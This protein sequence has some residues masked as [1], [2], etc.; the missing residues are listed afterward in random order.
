MPEDLSELDLDFAVAQ[1]V[2]HDLRHDDPL[3]GEAR[4][5]LIRSV[6]KLARLADHDT[7]ARGEA[8][9]ISAQFVTF[10]RLHA[11]LHREFEQ[12]AAGAA[13]L[14]V[15][16]QVATEAEE[17]AGLR[18]ALATAERRAQ[19][20]EAVPE[21]R[22]ELTRLSDA[23]ARAQQEVWERTEL[24][25]T[26]RAETLFLGQERV[27]IIA[28]MEAESSGCATRWREANA[29]C[30]NAK[31]PR[32]GYRMRSRRCARRSS[33]PNRRPMSVPPISP[34]WRP[35]SAGYVKR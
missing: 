17:M 8:Q 2:R 12:A 27:A 20:A 16:E 24:I 34:G 6:Y 3:I 29:S 18:E 4:Q 9:K 11:W 14:R 23:L 21:I 13:E 31:W 26:M 5:S 35:N 15:Q 33:A 22:A 7:A 19:G 10:Q 32:W 30:S 1:L 28:S 25:E